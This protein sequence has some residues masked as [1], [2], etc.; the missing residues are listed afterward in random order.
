LASDKFPIKRGY[1]LPAPRSGTPGHNSQTNL[2]R[3]LDDEVDPKEMGQK[4]VDVDKKPEDLEVDHIDLTVRMTGV[5][6]FFWCIF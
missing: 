5:L 2:R 6:F 3:R 4:D 1:T